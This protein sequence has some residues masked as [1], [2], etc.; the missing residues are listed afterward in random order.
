M[1][2]PTPALRGSEVAPGIPLLGGY[3]RID[4]PPDAKLLIPTADPRRLR[5]TQSADCAFNL[6]SRLTQLRLTHGI[7]KELCAIM[8][9]H[10][11]V[12]KTCKRSVGWGI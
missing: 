2:R 4:L 12:G 9:Q 8:R 10:D 6:L 3:Q 11:L 1:P 5:Q 7:Q